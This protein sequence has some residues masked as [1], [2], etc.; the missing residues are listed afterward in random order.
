MSVLVHLPSPPNGQS[1]ILKRTGR[2]RKE[3]D[4]GEEEEGEEEEE[5]SSIK[6]LKRQDL[7]VSRVLPRGRRRRGGLKL[8]VRLQA[9]ERVQT[10]PN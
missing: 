6:N 7:A 5:R 8:Y 3:K 2:R 4:A 9:R 1:K 10:K